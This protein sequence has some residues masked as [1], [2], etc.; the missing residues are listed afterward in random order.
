M[1]RQQDST[2]NSASGQ[3]QKPNP[4]RELIRASWIDVSRNN[5]GELLLKVFFEPLNG[6]EVQYSWMPQWETVRELIF[7]AIVVEAMNTGN[8][9]ELALFSNCL[10][11]CLKVRYKLTDM[12][13]GQMGLEDRVLRQVVKENIE[14]FDREEAGDA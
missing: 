4:T 13:K 14:C 1:P 9:K 11:L 12:L 6:A 3:E 5:K 2:A 8:S 7:S 10:K